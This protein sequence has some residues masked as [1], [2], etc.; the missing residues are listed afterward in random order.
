MEQ[1][2]RGKEFTVKLGNHRGAG[3]A[4]FKDLNKAKVNVHASC[5][6]SI[7]S[8]AY[9]SIVPDDAERTERALLKRGITPT[10]ED[11]LLIEMPNEPGALAE[12]LQGISELGVDVRS[13]YVTAS[14]NKP[15]LAVVKT[16]D[17]EKV[18]SEG[19]FPGGDG[20]ADA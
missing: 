3:A 4:L 6:Y 9:F 18:I 16:T 7:S 15:A 8:E 5:C 2:T 14:V 17:N 13:A 19:I 1:I 20:G 11:V 12:T 10:I